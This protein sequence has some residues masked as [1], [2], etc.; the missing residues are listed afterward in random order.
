MPR[1]D[2][3][4]LKRRPDLRPAAAGKAAQQEPAI[5]AIRDAERGMA[6]GVRRA[7][8]DPPVV[9]A[10]AGLAALKAGQSP[11][12]SQAACVERYLRPEPR[13]RAGLLL[14]RNRAATSCIDLSDGSVKLSD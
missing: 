12:G 9:A 2:R 14:G 6:I 7:A 13:V 1:P 3:P 11:V 4:R 8:R 10:A 5:G